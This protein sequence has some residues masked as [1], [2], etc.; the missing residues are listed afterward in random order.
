MGTPDNNLL[1]TSNT[2]NV[3][4]QAIL[5]STSFLD[6]VASLGISSGGNQQSNALLIN[7]TI[8]PG[9]NGGPGSPFLQPS[10]TPSLFAA[11]SY[12]LAGSIPLSNMRGTDPLT[13]SQIP[14]PQST[15]VIPTLPNFTIMA[16]GTV[17]ANG[18]GDFDGRPLD[19]RDDAKIYAGKGFTFNGS[20]TLPVQRDAL[21]NILR[22]NSGKA[23]L[24]T[25][26]IAV[27]QGY[28]QSN[29]PSN[30][31]AGL[32]PP[33][34]V[35]KQTVNVPAYADLKQQELT[36]R[37]PSGTPT[38]TFDIRQNPILN[39]TD[40]N[41]KFPTAGT[42]SQPKVVRVTNGSL[43]I[44][45]GINL[46]NTVIIV[47]SGD[48]TLNNSQCNFNNVALITNNGNINLGNIQATG[49][50]A[51]A[52]G[53]LTMSGN[54]RF[55]GNTLLA[56]GTGDLTFNGATK[57]LGNSQNLRAIAQGNLVFNGSEN[58]RGNFLTAKNFTMNGRSALLGTIGAKGNI[59]F[60]GQT[61]VT[62]IAP[63]DTPAP[64]ITAALVRDT[65]PGNTTNT[66]K[67]TFDATIA[68][69][70]AVV[71][72]LQSFTAGFDN[73][74]VSQ[75]VNVMADRQADG[76]FRFSQSR[77][78]QIFGG[79][80][81]DGQHTLHLVAASTV[82]A[83]TEDDRGERRG[84][85]SRGRE[86]DDGRE[87]DDCGG[88]Q[89]ASTSFDLI[90]TLDTKAPLVSSPDLLA[91]SDSGRSNTDN[92]TNQ[93]KP[94]IGG[95][96]EAGSAIQLFSGGQLVA[97]TTTKTD[98]T[99]QVTLSNALSNGTYAL[100]AIA[101]DAAGNVS[102]ITSPLSIIIDAL[103]PTLTLTKPVTTAPI[104]I[105]DKLT[106][107]FDGTGS[108]IA[109]ASYR[110]DNGPEIALVL[111][112]TGEFDQ[113]FNL[114]GITNGSH[115]LTISTVDVAGNSLSSSYDVKT[116]QDSEGPI[117]AAQLV[118]DSGSSRSDA[119]TFNPSISGIVT[120]ASAVSKF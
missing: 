18:G 82:G 22:D 60:N 96:A 98:G 106:G 101:T 13:G 107:S 24:A 3:F 27:A 14:T 36:Q 88:A 71:G 61:T 52:S 72:Q 77:L 45:Q 99:W 102:P 19:P 80:L 43:T 110:F 92:I 42:S 40:W 114:T 104:R 39:A 67:L 44:P 109:S 55:V 30:Q 93:T 4:A 56:T 95:T 28:T 84:F 37:I 17:T 103:K 116:G 70:I 53:S 35:A 9:A 94:Q 49:L 11:D 76:T 87:Y 8:L 51:L 97:T 32:V 38:V 47:E 46:S 20:V 10:N 85:D 64:T 108:S 68:G 5:Q 12:A 105:G 16:E 48:I 112:T 118:Q 115:V 2:Q 59:T 74:P 65:A 117:I 79:T 1:G 34:V 90:F 73:K 91:V 29:G 54:S 58:T 62:A 57:D 41:R 119:I 7:P 75:Y 15:S 69:S 86:C 33:P 6:G 31:Y 113:A 23:I 78:A 25:G 100:T 63:T 66:D 120:D 26:T 89:Q 50:S 21:G 111:N 83:Q 81:P